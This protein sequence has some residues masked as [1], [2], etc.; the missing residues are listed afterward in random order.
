MERGCGNIGERPSLGEEARIC[1]HQQDTL[2][3]LSALNAVH[4]HEDQCPENSSLRDVLEQGGRQERQANEEVAEHGG[5]AVLAH[6]CDALLL[7]SLGQRHHELWRVG[8]GPG[9]EGQPKERPDGVE[10]CHASERGVEVAPLAPMAGLEAPQ[11]SGLHL[12]SKL[13]V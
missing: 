10:N 7:V 11:N 8:Q 6:A 2:I 4:P 5:Q 12:E 13:R 9:H 1:H 3:E